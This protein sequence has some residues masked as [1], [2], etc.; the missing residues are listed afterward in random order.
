M[1]NFNLLNKALTDAN[2]SDKEFR[3]LYL[4]VNN[5]SL[6]NTNEIEMYNGFIMDKLDICERQA[7]RLTSS[8]V[9]KGYII[10]VRFGASKKKNGNVYR[11]KADIDTDIKLDKNVP[12][13][14]NKK[15]NI[16][17]SSQS[18]SRTSTGTREK[19]NS[20]N[21]TE[22]KMET[23]LKQERTHTRK[24]DNDYV[25]RCLEKF[26]TMLKY[27]YSITDMK[28]YDEYTN[29]ILDFYNSIDQTRFTE[30]Q[31]GLI[32]KKCETWV[33]ISNGKNCYFNGKSEKTDNNDESISMEP[34]QQ[35]TADNTSS[36][37]D[38]S[39]ADRLTYP[40][41]SIDEKR[42]SPAKETRK[43][44]KVYKEQSIEWLDRM[45]P[46]YENYDSF[47]SAMH[48]KFNETYGDWD[49]GKDKNA[50]DLW[51]FSQRYASN[52]YSDLAAANAK[53]EKELDAAFDEFIKEVSNDE[54][55]WEEAKATKPELNY[56]EWHE[57]YGHL[58][59]H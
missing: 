15:K 18:S 1:F 24:E 49:Y 3:L 6:N 4:I 12:P 25:T 28:I 42:P 54:A 47:T 23:E 26:D 46:R 8:L 43:C 32:E 56:E 14:K 27:L 35:T 55:P 51:N 36:Y 29:D 10:K 30:K 33:K 2:L 17:N 38:Q 53:K 9:E 44:G 37:E 52:Y 41:S 16:I 13:Y 5:M 59:K 48:K 21:E 7:R 19:N 31:R 45:L 50:C 11:L 57:K 39:E 58:L 34:E 20:D 22:K 40:Q